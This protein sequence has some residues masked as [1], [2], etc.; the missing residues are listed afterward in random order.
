MKMSLLAVASLLA[1]T[2]V[3]AAQENAI[4]NGDFEKGKMG[5]RMEPGIHVIDAPDATGT[6][7]KV[8]EVEV[9]KNDT[10]S[11]STRLDIKSKTKALVITFR[12]MPRPGFK[13]V[14]PEGNQVTVRMARTGGATFCG[15][16]IGPNG[17]WKDIKWDFSS[18]QGS[19]SFTFVMEFHT[20]EGKIWIDN[21]VVQEL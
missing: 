6:S 17:Q 21:I 4:K 5:W 7:N 11:I 10:K 18:F 15:W 8:L 1:V 12:V 9:D 19:R 14:S 20:G 13:S 16:N 2:C 3:A